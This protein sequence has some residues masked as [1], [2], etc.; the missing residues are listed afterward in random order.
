[1]S[2]VPSSLIGQSK[3]EIQKS[4]IPPSLAFSLLEILVA[5]ALLSFIILGLLSMFLQTQKAFRNSMKQVDVLEAGRAATDFLSRELSQITPSQMPLTM[6]FYAAGSFSFN[7]PLYQQLPGSVEQRTNI[8]QKL[9]FIS[10]YNQDWIG[11]GYQVISDYTNAGVGTL[12]RFSTNRARA[13]TPLLFTDYINAPLARLNRVVDGIVHF[14]VRAFATNGFPIE[15]MNSPILGFRPNADTNGMVQMQ[16]STGQWEVSVPDQADY[17]FTSNAVP[18]F[19]EI[20]VGIL[21]PPIFERWRGIGSGNVAAQLNYLS[22]H[23]AN[24]HIFRQRIPIQNVDYT[25]YQ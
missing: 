24:V 9:F 5:V 6:N 22:N 2:G 16:F 12:Y 17:Y 20:E 8:V 1:L 14:R 25:A 15:P 18:A 3:I 13:Q 19:V 23:V 21:E 10:R 7:N 4:K 11:T